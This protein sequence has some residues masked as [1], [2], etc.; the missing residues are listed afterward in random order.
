MSY[1]VP[2]RR[3]DR[4]ELTAVERRRLDR[5]IRKAR[6]SEQAAAVASWERDRVLADLQD[7]GVKLAALAE[8]MGETREMVRQR[9]LRGRGP[10]P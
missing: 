10:R 3:P 5:A 9:A 1:D 6:D 7:A 8:V 2:R 4:D